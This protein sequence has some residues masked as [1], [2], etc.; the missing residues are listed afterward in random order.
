LRGRCDRRFRGHQGNVADI[1]QIPDP[2]RFGPDPFLGQFQG[3][4]D[5][6]GVAFFA[7][8]PI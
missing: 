3:Q 6:C 2:L 4:A 8:I 7:V 5:R 1:F